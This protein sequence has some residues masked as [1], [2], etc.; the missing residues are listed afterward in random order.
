MVKIKKD[1]PMNTMKS[2]ATLVYPPKISVSRSDE[3]PSSW[4]GNCKILNNLNVS[5][6]GIRG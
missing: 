5:I 4:H 2:I 6:E 1:V 3:C